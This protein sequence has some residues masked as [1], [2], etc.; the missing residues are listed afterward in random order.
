MKQ[1]VYML[2]AAADAN[3]RLF[4][5]DPQLIFD[6]L[7]TGLAV[8]VL[9]VILSYLLFN[10]ARDFLKKRQDKI[11]NEL[12]TA[13]KDQETA[14]R[15]KAD[16]EAKLKDINKEAEQILTDA[17]KKAK[18]SEAQIIEEAKEEAVL[19]RRR[20]MNEIELEKKRALDDMKQEM[21]SIASIMAAKVIG[22]KM[23]VTIQES[24]VN[25]TLK[26]MGDE[27]WLS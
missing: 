12:E 24:L 22:Q 6:A 13:A 8:F 1:A 10:P 15:L 9:F 25:E 26:E 3:E 18:K 4:E 27:T 20:A 14:A 17:R 16:Y 11:Q 7:L 5:L 21:I 2:A 23:D 19:I